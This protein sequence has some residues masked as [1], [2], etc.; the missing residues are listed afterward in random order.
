MRCKEL[1][2]LSSVKLI[3]RSMLTKKKTPVGAHLEK[4]QLHTF[5]SF[6]FASTFP[7]TA[8]EMKVIL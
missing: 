5:N 4:Y 8:M 6:S 2:Q 7:P 1:K 3:E